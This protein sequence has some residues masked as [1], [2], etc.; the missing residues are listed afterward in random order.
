MKLKLRIKTFDRKGGRKSKKKA[1]GRAKGQRI[2]DFIRANISRD[3]SLALIAR[4]CG[5]HPLSVTGSLK[6]ITGLTFSAFVAKERM[7]MAAKLIRED[8]MTIEQIARRIGYGNYKTFQMHFHAW[9]NLNPSEYRLKKR[10]Y[11]LYQEGTRQ[12][13]LKRQRSSPPSEG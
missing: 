2:A 1:S 4:R 3:L 8:A 7:E 9:F 5:L 11:R 10:G 6:N 12:K 13:R